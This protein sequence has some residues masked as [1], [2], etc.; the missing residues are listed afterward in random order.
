MAFLRPDGTPLSGRSASCRAFPTFACASRRAAARRSWLATPWGLPQKSTCKPIRAVCLW[1]VPSNTIR[2]QTLA[3]LRNR[4]HPYR[5]MLDAKFSG[6]VTI[7]DLSEVPVCPAGYAD[8]RD[9]HHRCH[10]GGALRVEDTEGRKVYEPAGVLQ[11]HFTGLSAE[12][13]A[14]LEKREDGSIPYS[15]CNVLRLWRPVVIMDEAHNARTQLSFD[16]LAR[17]NPSCIIEFTAT[18]ETTHKPDKGQF[19][20][21]ILHHVSAAELKAE[22]MIKLPI[23]LETRSEWKEVIGDAVHTRQML[24]DTAHKEEE[25]TGEY[26]RPIVLLQAQPKNQHKETLTVEVVRQSLID[27]FKIPEDQI[28]IATGQNREIDDVDLFD[29]ACQIRFI[30]TVAALKEGWDCSFAYVL[31]SVAE[32]S[33]ARSVEQL[34][35]R[36]LRLP[37]VKKK[38]HAELNCAYALAA[39]SR[40]IS[41]AQSLK[42]ALIENGF[43]KMEAELYVSPAD[44][45]T[46]FGAGTMVGEVEC[47]VLE[48]PNLSAL[49]ADLRER[50]TFALGKLIVRG[51]V[52][53]E[54]KADLEKCFETPGGKKAAEIIFHLA[55]GRAAV[56]KSPE[57]SC[58][59]IPM[60][61]IRVDGWLELF[62]ESHFLDTVWKLSDCDVKLTEFPSEFVSGAAGEIDVV[63]GKVEVHFVDQIH[64]QLR[65]LGDHRK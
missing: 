18:P 4:K 20:S 25:Q 63:E 16:T 15:L 9:L 10:A 27:D 24:E 19:A 52:T 45:G 38:T 58:F 55:S 33:S 39:S 61:A 59:R 65:L 53:P 22:D 64:R 7:M 51:D 37:H 41:A 23:K 46:F 48:T 50:V 34:L 49:P 31:C 28:A 5:Q 60:L 30:I 56:P 57:R 47:P 17:F 21:N 6:Q 1:L 12:L 13:E 29:R 26:I 43:Q 42:D 62:D 40:F 3:A 32:I 44:Q 8:R 14:Q 54:N 35:G 36:I 2:D 11:H